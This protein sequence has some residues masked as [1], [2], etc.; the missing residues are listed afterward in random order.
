MINPIVNAEEKNSPVYT[1]N[2]LHIIVYANEPEFIY[3][4]KSNPTTGYSWFIHNYDTDLIE[5]VSHQFQRPDSKLMGAPG[6]ERWI[7]R[8]KPAA[9]NVS[10]Q[11]TIRLVYMRPW[12]SNASGTPLV[13]QITTQKK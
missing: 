12:E 8:L 2:N 3:Q 4:L 11:L 10:Q 7:F 5:L 13:I 6:F 9:F 1:E